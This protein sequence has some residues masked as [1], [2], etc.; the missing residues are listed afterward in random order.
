MNKPKRIILKHS[1]LSI[2]LLYFICGICL[3][4]KAPVKFGKVNIADLEMKVYGPDSSAPAV[5][6]CNYGYFN[7]KSFQFKRILRIKFLKKEGLNWADQVFPTSS[8]TSIRGITFNLENGNIIKEKLKHSSIF[9]ERITGKYYRMRVAM[10]NVKVGSI[11]D[12]EFTHPL[13]P[14]VWYFQQL[15]PVKH[16]ELIIENSPYISFRKN[17]FGFEKLDIVGNN[18]WVA[19]DMPAF[20]KEPYVN[21]VDNYITKF[22]FDILTVLYD[23]ITTTWEAVNKELMEHTYFGIAIKGALYLNSIAK[24]IREKYSTNEERLIAAYESVKKVKWN[25]KERLFTTSTNT[26]YAYRNEIG[27]SADINL[28]LLQLLKKLDFNAF[29]VALS[30]RENGLLSPV[31]P[32]YNKLNYV[33]VKTNIGEKEYLLDATEEH[34]PVGLI[35]ERCLNW[36][37]RIIDTE[38]SG[39]IDLVTDK[40]HRERIIYDLTLTDEYTL[41]GKI[42]CCNYEYAA[43][44]FRKHYREFNSHEEY[45]EDYTKDKAGLTVKDFKI[46]NLDSIYL[47]LRYECEVII[48]KQTNVIDDLI[49]INPLLYS[50]IKDNPFKSNERKYPVDFAYPIEKTCVTGLKIPENYIIQE[51]PESINV[52]IPGRKASLIYNIKAL[53]NKIY[54]TSKFNINVALIMEDEYHNLKEL[55]SQLVKKHSEPIILK[56]Q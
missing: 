48:N 42:N 25:K 54:I 21:S 46:V 17:F 56:K 41:T 45:L 14:L 50:Q 51:M 31:Y 27:N 9:E 44:D 3:S 26:G 52:M 23:D 16:S 28:M 47:P 7:S 5:I 1:I 19:R 33:I 4:Q 49:Y 20:K 40:E 30:T 24:D 22:E 10:P 36:K 12:I 35:P 43:F 11:I 13:I 38:K 32:S 34:M 18:R 55:Y 39:W 8:K 37:G 53:G 15:I 2:F 6:L 29:P